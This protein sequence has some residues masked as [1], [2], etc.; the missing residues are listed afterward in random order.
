MEREL[1]EIQGR[2][3]AEL[4]AALQERRLPLAPDGNPIV[5]ER[6][7]R[8]DREAARLLELRE[9]RIGE[10]ETRLRL[11]AL[12]SGLHLRNGSLNRS[13]ELSQELDGPD[14]SYLH[15][16]M[17]RMEGDFSNAKYW[18]RLAGP[19]P[20]AETWRRR[21]EQLL[22][23]TPDAEPALARRLRREPGVDPALL[24]DLAAASAL[25][26][27]AGADTPLLERVQELELELLLEALAE[28]GED[29]S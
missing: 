7:R 5:E 29:R 10:E 20:R 15:G 3:A 17:H 12:V 22:D 18:F 14:G 9:R 23:G 8:L 26:G 11:L 6:E 24:T 19:H 4:A 28:A 16:M 2:L 13:H 21:T 27:H 1:Q 25:T